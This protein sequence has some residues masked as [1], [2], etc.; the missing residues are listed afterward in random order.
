MLRHS[1]PTWIRTDSAEME[2]LA[3]AGWGYL[4]LGFFSGLGLLLTSG[5]RLTTGG[6]HYDPGTIAWAAA[7][8][9]LSLSG[10]ML[11]RSLPPLTERSV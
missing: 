8:F 2:P 11:L 7:I 4:L 10:W 5:L 6:A 1:L 3:V 9:V